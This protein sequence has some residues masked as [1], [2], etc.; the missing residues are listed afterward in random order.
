MSSARLV[1]VS[2]IPPTLRG[3]P[4]DSCTSDSLQSRTLTS[5]RQTGFVP[6]SLHTTAELAELPGHA[7]RLAQMGVAVLEVRQDDRERLPNLLASLEALLAAH[8][9]AL[10]AITNADILCASTTTLPLAL[11]A[12]QPHQALVGRRTNVA[13]DAEPSAAAAGK[14]DLYGFDFFAIHAS[15]LRRA[16]PLIPEE[17]VFGR[18]WWDLFLPLALLAAG[19]EL[20]DPGDNLFLHSIHQDR[21]S[22]EQWLRFGQQADE[23]FL[24]LLDQQGCHGFAQRWSRQRRRYI[25]RWPGFRW[26]L[27]RFQDQWRALRHQ[28]R[29][30]PLYLYDVSGAINALI[31][32]HLAGSAFFDD[33]QPRFSG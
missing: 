3:E 15:S 14:R 9:T 19:L 22:E 5:W 32:E 1:L 4:L 29:L 27:Q 18:P 17:L 6:L 31:D 20:L 21:W 10:L 26:Q 28:R 2:S 33:S 16:L 11:Q 25:L 24:Q 8:P 23:R 7:A 12:L 30:L 13:S